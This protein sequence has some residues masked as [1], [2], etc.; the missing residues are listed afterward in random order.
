[1]A[2]KLSADKNPSLRKIVY[3]IPNDWYF[4]THRLHLAQAAR[5]AGYEV[6]IATLPGEYVERIKAE[7][8][9][10]HPL[11]LQR[12]HAT[13]WSELKTIADI[14]SLHRR[15]RPDIIHQV[16][17]RVVL[18]G[19]IA[20]KITRIPT[21]NAITG[22]GYLFIANGLKERMMRS[23]LSLIF[24][25]FLKGRNVTIFQ[26]EDDRGIF[27]QRKI[28]SK[29]QTVLIPGAGV[30][31]QIFAPTPEPESVMTILLTARMLRDKGI[32][33][34]VEASRILKQ[35]GNIFRVVLAGMLDPGN[36]TAITEAVINEWQT[37]GL[38]EWIGHQS[39]IAQRLAE[40]HIV[41]L[42]SYREGLPLSLIEAAAA[43]RPIVTTNVPGCRE[44]VEDGWN[45]LLVP[46][47]DADSLAEA[48]QKL[49]QDAQL[50]KQFGLHGRQL[51]LEKFTQEKI[52]HQTMKVYQ[53]LI[54][55]CR[56]DDVT[57]IQDKTI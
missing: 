43:G 12:L 37:E 28:V 56:I 15:V 20:A 46:A 35:R 11:K 24:R 32:I 22:L 52:I 38:V 47:K 26:N 19:S 30:N 3:L 4:W 10:F 23:I 7:G 21:V 13:P 40:C 57:L 31:T 14:V 5:D 50:R 55:K 1:M 17:L 25:F 36:P 18:Y 27:L 34:L 9:I 16:T 8:F 48:L 54:Q 39:N 45:G 42:P 6:T 53:S 33:E 49:M 2:K 51:V 29:N 44:I 41:C